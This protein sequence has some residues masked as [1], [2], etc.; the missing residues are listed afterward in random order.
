MEIRDCLSREKDIEYITNILT[1]AAVKEE[2]ISLSI[3]G[4][5]GTGKTYFINMLEKA[6]DK[7]KTK[8]LV[9]KFDAWENDYYDDPIIGI[10]DTLVDQLN[11]LNRDNKI[12]EDAAKKIVKAFIS[13][14]CDFI[15]NAV[16][17]KIG[18]KPIKNTKKIINF[19]KNCSEDTKI[20][21]DFNPNNKIK[22]A[23][24][25]VISFLNELADREK[26][27][28]LFVI[29]EIDRC[30]PTYALKILQRV[31]HI[32]ENVKKSSCLLTVDSKQLDHTIKIVYGNDA[33]S[34]SYLKKIID[35]QYDFDEGEVNAVFKEQYLL[36]YRKL[37][38][39]PS[40]GINE[41]DV[42]GFLEIAF[43]NIGIRESLKIIN[44]SFYAHKMLF[45][46]EK[47]PAELMC[48]ELLMTWARTKYQNNLIQGLFSLFFSES[49]DKYP[50]IKYLKKNDGI[51]PYRF[52]NS[53]LAPNGGYCFNIF[54][55]KSLIV[56]FFTDPNDMLLFRTERIKERYSYGHGFPKDFEKILC[57][58]HC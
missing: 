33:K 23:K 2:N 3:N 7:S 44:N 45:G 40:R 48:M 50:L 37:F 49:G 56:S 1:S 14:A 53:Y 6:L 8:Y 11:S 24:K 12:I 52:F 15:D 55:F 29:D 10:L 9:F 42:N 20:S 58:I 13:F 21:S 39:N 34:E 36:E 47:Q 31:H 54:D 57:K 51:D 43:K 22:A 16:S 18:F 41:S 27:R 38:D 4:C 35:L 30:V 19:F 5:W 46:D 26:C 17:N 28:I 25:L 32:S